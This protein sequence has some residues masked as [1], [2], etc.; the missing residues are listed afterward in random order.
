MN[1][2][3][4]VTI[5]YF[6]LL[7]IGGS[8]LLHMATDISSILSDNAISDSIIRNYSHL[9]TRAG[10]YGI[11]MFMVLLLVSFILYFLTKR[12]N[13]IL[14]SN[15][16]YTF[17]TLYIYITVNRDFYIVQNIEYAQQ[18][19]YWLTVFMGIF[20]VVGSILV[21]AIGYITIRNY[22]KKIVRDNR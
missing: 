5:I 17:F 9:Q 19:E 3:K 15:I 22:T 16:V 13:Y 7:A 8:V 11:V 1:R 2:V 21:S 6:L 14:L 10:M 20:Y 4:I 12:Y 18:G